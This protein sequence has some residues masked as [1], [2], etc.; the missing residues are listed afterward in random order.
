MRW[1]QYSRS[2]AGAARAGEPVTLSLRPE[3]V[4]MLAAGAS[5]PPGFNH[6]KGTVREQ[7]FHGDSIR[8]TV[9][10]G[11]GRSIAVHRQ[12]EA[13]IDKV[14]LPAIGSPIDM[15]VDPEN[16]SLFSG[17]STDASETPA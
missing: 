13:G 1:R 14:A 4:A 17:T 12:L 6:L 9:D 3:K 5:P 2:P 8:L 11:I 16:V 10:I 15:A 7:F